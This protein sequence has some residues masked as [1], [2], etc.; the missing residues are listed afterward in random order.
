M[1]RAHSF[2]VPVLVVL[3]AALAGGFIWIATSQTGFCGR[4][5]PPSGWID[6]AL[7]VVA[8]GLACVVGAVALS[9]GPQTRAQWAIAAASLIEAA[10]AVA[11]VFYIA[12]RFAHAYDCG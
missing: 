3:G 1:P 4:Y 12:A 9:A 11:L 7:I 5:P 2:I 10:A 6:A 8:I